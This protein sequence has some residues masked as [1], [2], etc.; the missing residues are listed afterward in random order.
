MFWDLMLYENCHPAFIHQ[1][2]K[3]LDILD[4][5]VIYTDTKKEYLQKNV[6]KISF[7]VWGTG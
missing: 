4:S 1:I 7:R 5:I 2:L 6:H 3:N